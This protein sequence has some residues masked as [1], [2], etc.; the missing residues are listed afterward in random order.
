MKM[1]ASF[2]GGMYATVSPGRLVVRFWATF[3]LLALLFAAGILTGAA[4]RHLH[5]PL[6]RFSASVVGTA[7]A[8]IGR[9]SSSGGL[10]RYEGFDMEIVDACDGLLPVCIYLSAVLAF[11]S[12]WRDRAWGILI[13]V[14]AIFLLNLIRLV[15][16]AVLGAWKPDLLDWVHIY[17]WQALII[18]LSMAIWVFWVERFVRPRPETR[19]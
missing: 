2:Q 3:L 4:Q 7:L 1:V 16:L 8:R 9:A 17:V 12:R 5:D 19:A 13:G 6:A 11:P 10:V 15:T 14:P 18:G